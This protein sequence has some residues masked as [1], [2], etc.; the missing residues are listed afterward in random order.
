MD[1]CH[2][3][4]GPPKLYPNGH[5]KATLAANAEQGTKKTIIRILLK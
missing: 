1:I 4:Y 2:C 3:L 5:G